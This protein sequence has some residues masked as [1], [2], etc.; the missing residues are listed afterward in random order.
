MV[1]DGYDRYSARELVN[2]DPIYMCL[3]MVMLGQYSVMLV[4][5]VMT[6]PTAIVAIDHCF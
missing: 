2:Y 4:Y 3:H 6:Y 1:Y 5:W